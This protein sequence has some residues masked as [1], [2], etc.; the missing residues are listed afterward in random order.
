MKRR[1][2]TPYGRAA[3]VLLILLIGVLGFY[4][5]R[6][7][8]VPVPVTDAEARAKVTEI[9]ASTYSTPEELCEHALFDQKCA[10]DSEREKN[11]QPPTDITIVCTWPMGGGG[12]S[13][14]VEVESVTDDGQ[15]YRSSVIVSRDF[16][17]LSVWS[18]PYWDDMSIRPVPDHTK[19]DPPEQFPAEVSSK[20]AY[21]PCDIDPTP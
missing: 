18:L 19:Q 2:S 17:T 20:V 14:V 4:I 7:L 3:M 15:P 11:F 9:S 1:L 10:Q 12:G 16:N 5:G 8:M 13:R 6:A 21:D